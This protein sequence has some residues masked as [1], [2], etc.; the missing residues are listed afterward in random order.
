M[1]CRFGA[2]HPDRVVPRWVQDEQVIVDR[3]EL[4]ARQTLP[5]V[6]DYNRKR[7]LR[8]RTAHGQ[9]QRE[10]HTNPK[11]HISPG[12]HQ[13]L[14]PH[15]RTP[16]TKWPQGVATT[17]AAPVAMSVLW[18]CFDFQVSDQLFQDPS[19]PPDTDGDQISLKVAGLFA[20]IGGIERGFHDAGHETVLLCEID[21]AARAVLEA[22]FPKVEHF[23]KDVCDVTDLRG[24][25]LVAAG[26]PCQDLSQAGRTAGIRGEQ[27]GLV[28]EVLRLIRDP[29]TA[30]K[31]LLLE[32]VPFMLQLDGGEA[33]KFL[34]TQLGALGFAWAYRVVDARS[35]G[36]PQRRQR[37]ILLAS[38]TEDPRPVLFEEDAGE[39]ELE[40]GED[41]VCGFYWTEGL[42]GLGWAVDGIPTLKG[43]SGLGIAS[44]PGIWFPGDDL[45]L[46]TPEIRDAER[47]QGFEAGWTA[48]EGVEHARGAR[49][50][51]VGNA[52]NVRMAE[53]V[54]ARLSSD[55]GRWDVAGNFPSEVSGRWPTA[56]W[57]R[58]D[59]AFAVDVSAWPVRREYE[60]LRDF[61]DYE[62]TPLS[63]RAAS[64]FYSRTQKAKLRFVERF[65][66]DVKAHVDA[67]TLVPA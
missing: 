56:A 1:Q 32:N 23:V 34:T 45:P 62:T 39:L 63:Q 60:R 42:R 9:G 55:R 37:V 29:E 14:K 5:N 51:M 7:D 67:T 31:W 44:P 16:S 36:I 52:V 41:S 25:D 46:R 19:E 53:W 48:P 65:I 47:L 40:F 13:W 8:A 49:W 35:F 3:G 10:L 17:I 18:T 30:P 22:R 15:E 26:F 12:R 21:D 20:G 4:P 59:N 43:G 2:D 57:G 6:N 27:S 50:K 28:A 64:G 24:A 11:W 33:M 54:G 61:L 58:G 38:R 66:E